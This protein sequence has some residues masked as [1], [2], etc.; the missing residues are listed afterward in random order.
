[1]G[2]KVGLGVFLDKFTSTAR[3]GR[4][5]WFGWLVVWLPMNYLDWW[6]LIHPSIHHTIFAFIQIRCLLSF[7]LYLATLLYFGIKGKEFAFYEEE[8]YAY[9]AL[10]CTFLPYYKREKILAVWASYYVTINIIT[11]PTLSLLLFPLYS[12]F[13][14]ASRLAVWCSFAFLFLSFSFPVSY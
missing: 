5:I 12:M 1:M 13:E 2:E 11:T 7:T 14:K 10:L 6:A 3:E 4:S 9:L 8:N